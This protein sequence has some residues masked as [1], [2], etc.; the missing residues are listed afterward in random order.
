MGKLRDVV[1]MAAFTGALGLGAAAHADVVFYSY[2]TGA[3]TLPLVTNF[4]EDTVGAAPTHIPASPAGMSWSGSGEIVDTTASGLAAEPGVAGGVYGT[5]NFLNILS[6]HSE[7]LTIPAAAEITKIG[8]YVGSLDSYNSLIFTLQGGAQLTYTG[9]DLGAFSGADNGDQLAGNTNGVFDFS[10]KKAVTS[11]QFQSAGN[12]FEIAGIN[13]ADAP[14][15]ATWAMLI[16]GV[17]M[18][19]CAARRRR[20]AKAV[21][22]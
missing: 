5:G 12:S 3:P 6:G 22:A 9:A 8:L 17:A 15:P 10:F 7:T 21:T 18:I 20:E 1:A 14:E 13:A 16:L 11:I 19:G 2:G 4:S